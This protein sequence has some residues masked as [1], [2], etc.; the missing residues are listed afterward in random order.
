LS[1]R[2]EAGST[3]PSFSTVTTTTDGNGRV[4]SAS[5]TVTETVTLPTW[6]K[7][8][9]QCEPIKKEWNRFHAALSTHE[10]GH[11]AIDRKFFASIDK[12]LVGLKDE[13]VDAKLEEIQKKAQQE[14]DDF[15][16][17]AKTDHGRNNGTKIDAGIRCSEKV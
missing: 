5:L 1:N 11:V 17:P 3:R 14:N 9:D 16:S 7:A 15:D 2:G 13:D 10:D 12:K 8:D 4:T 6:T